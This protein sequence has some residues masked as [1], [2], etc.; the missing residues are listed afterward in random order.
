MRNRLAFMR[1][2]SRPAAGI[3]ALL[4]AVAFAA[5][6]ASAADEGLASCA[7]R[8]DS[9][10]CSGSVA[11]A[12]ALHSYDD[13]L[14]DVV[15][16][17]DISGSNVVTNDNF[18]LTIGAHIR[19]R[20]SFQEG[21]VYGIYF[22][23]DSNAATGTDA[24]S[25]APPGAEYSIEIAH[26]KTWLLRW[27]G[28]SFDPLTPRKPIATAWLD[29]LGPVLQVARADLGDPQSF[30]FAFVT[31]SGDYDHA[32]DTGMWSYEL[33]PFALTAGRLSVGRARAGKPVVA[34]MSVKRSDF[35]IPLGEGT[36]ACAARIG[37]KALHGRGAFARERVSCTW[38]LATNSAGKR[39]GGSV[40]VTFQGVIAK[41]VFSVQVR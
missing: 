3:V 27:H 15:T 11:G 29:G 30:K 12:S 35:A 36:V 39:L 18:V 26:G 25:G 20:S 9:L 37:E 7:A 32:P 41:R 13:N 19:G 40:Q 14:D 6:G 2:A 34:S 1:H 22:D 16:A 24:L 10:L 21:D 17:P 38:R 4:V 28:S 31:V 8:S 33:S 23:T 5:T